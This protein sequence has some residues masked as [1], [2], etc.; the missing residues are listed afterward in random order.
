MANVLNTLK[1]AANVIGVVPKDASASTA[2]HEAEAAASMTSMEA[3]QLLARK[4][5]DLTLAAELGKAL[6]ERNEE[7]R[8]QNDT[9]DQEYSERIEVSSKYRETL[10]GLL[11]KQSPVSF[12]HSKKRQ[13]ASASSQAA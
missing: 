3:K 5:A 9:L 12:R 2:D 13:L 1:A 4:E 6:L 7:L 10:C 11:C 8:L